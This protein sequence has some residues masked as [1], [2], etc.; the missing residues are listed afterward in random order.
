MIKLV[1]TD[2]DGTLLPETTTEVNPEIYEIVRELK[3]RGI[4]FAAAS[5]RQYESMLRVLGPV[6]EDI[7][8]LAE[9][10][11]QVMV[12][13]KPLSVT[14]IEQAVGEE[15]I[16]FV[17]ILPECELMLSTPG[18][19]YLETSDESLADLMLNSYK[20][21]AECVEDIL[22]YCDRC[23]KIAVYRR[24]GIEP[25][26]QDIMD[27]FGDRMSVMISGENWIDCQSPDIDKGKALSRVQRLL[28][29]SAEET[30]A[31][32]DNCNDIP[33]LKC[34]GEGYAVA[35]ADPRLK[36]VARYL[37]PACEEDGVIRTIKEQLLCDQGAET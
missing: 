2:L 1:V 16:Q 29:I 37:A 10:G 13:G 17:R 30:M 32:G 4:V 27:R 11:T 21:S 34:A 7:F 19:I 9:N 14:Y 6:A 25:V 18:R 15:L 31:F 12:R 8:F 22:P 33:L 24:D 3:E 20:V 35:N 23:I 5:G 26:F 28:R 36:K